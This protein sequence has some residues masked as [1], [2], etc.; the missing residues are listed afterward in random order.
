M[1]KTSA[2]IILTVLFLSGCFS[3][4]PVPTDKF[5][6]LQTS[7]LKAP[8]SNIKGTIAIRRFITNGLHNG[9]AILYADSSTPLKLEAYHYQYWIDV[10]PRLIKEHMVLSLRNSN[11]A[12]SIVSYDSKVKPDYIISGNIRRF[13]QIRG[14]NPGVSVEIELQLTKA[15]SRVPLILKDY[16]AEL[17]TPDSSMHEVVRVFSDALGNVYQQFIND[18]P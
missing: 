10:P 6:R 17:P 8:A 11:I 4:P 9:R 12:D 13:E 18:I 3:A 7:S 16:R 15:G 1:I 2:I 5:Y 14:S